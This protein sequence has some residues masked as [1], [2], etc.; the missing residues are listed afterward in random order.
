MLE[1]MCTPKTILFGAYMYKF[2]QKLF[3]EYRENWNR[4]KIIKKNFGLQEVN[5]FFWNCYNWEIRYFFVNKV[6]FVIRGLL[7]AINNI[8]NMFK[9]NIYRMH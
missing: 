7:E 2:V 1:C 8:R 3:H 6:G 9:N 4:A 5:L